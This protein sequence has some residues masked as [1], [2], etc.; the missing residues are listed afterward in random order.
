MHFVDCDCESRTQVLHRANFL[1]LGQTLLKCDRIRVIIHLLIFP[2]ITL[3]RGEYDLH[4]RA[5]LADLGNPLGPDVFKGVRAV[6]LHPGYQHW[7]FH[8]IP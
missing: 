1:G 7:T 2:Q 4:A 5:I 6:N 8:A 3:E